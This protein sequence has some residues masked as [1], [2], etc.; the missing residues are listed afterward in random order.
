MPQLQGPTTPYFLRAPKLIL[1][2][3]EYVEDYQRAYGDVFRVGTGSPPMVYIADP[4]V[5]K[6]IFQ[7]DPTCFEIPSRSVGGILSILVGENSLLLLDGQRHRRHRR[8]LMPP[9][10]GERM[11][12]Y[13]QLIC[14]ITEQVTGHWSVNTSF[15]V[16]PPMQE[17]TLRVILKAVFG[18]TQG[19][20]YDQLRQLLSTMLENLGT[21]LSAFFVFFQGLQQDWGPL[22]PWGRFV[23]LKAKVDQLI[24]EE[25][26]ERRDLQSFSGDD[27]LTLMMTARDDQGQALSDEELH[28]ELITLL[29]AGHE[30]T[31]SALS[32]A[33]YW[34]HALPQVQDKLR[35]ELDSLGDHPEPLE[36]ANLPYLN[37]VCQE[38]LRIYPVAPT[39]GIRITSQP[40]TIADYEFPT[41]SVLFPSI[42]LVHHSEK[43]Y[44]DSKAFK[45]ERFLERQFSPYEFFPFGG[46]HRSCI[47]AAFAMMEM[48]LVLTTILR[49]WTL[50]LANNRPVKPVRR[51]LTL[52]PA[53]SL[54]LRVRTKTSGES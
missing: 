13:G 43:L 1:H 22:S 42:Y 26:Q 9:F 19:P 34:I 10:H 6:G 17:I 5:I 46:G 7:A 8:L 47:G 44:P 49:N 37:A 12:A 51:G 20:R 52:A 21:P 48:K 50:E 25:I 15:K 32:W 23:R 40:M 41:G 30:T 27:I 28:D 14:D 16:R 4:D 11:R 18:L 31:A 39:T 45:P 36:L 54:Q 24:Y 3:L 38:T 29:I 35:Y 53:G 33:L 2:P